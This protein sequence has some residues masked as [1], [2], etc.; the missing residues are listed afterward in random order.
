MLRFEERRCED[1]FQLYLKHL[2]SAWTGRIRVVRL[3]LSPGSD[4]VTKNNEQ[5][6]SK[7]PPMIL[8]LAVSFDLERYS[9]PDKWLPRCVCG[10]IRSQKGV[11]R[12]GLPLLRCHYSCESLH[13]G[14]DML[15]ES[16]QSGRFIDMCVAPF[17]R[18]L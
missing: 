10:G 17:N 11:F 18:G 13:G 12:A 3:W 2:T 7:V 15:P 8:N 14:P 4:A 16:S 1:V 5:K 9:A 6:E